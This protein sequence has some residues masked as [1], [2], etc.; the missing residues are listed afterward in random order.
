MALTIG[1]L[2]T[3]AAHVPTFTDLVRVADP[4][5]RTV[6]RVAPELL[7][8]AREHG[9]G[10]ALPARVASA[11]RGLAGECDVVVCTCSTIGALAVRAREVAVPVLRIDQPMADAAVAAGRRIGILAALDSTLAP[12]RA[13]LTEQAA[14]AG[15][16]IEVVERV[17]A[18][19]WELFEAGDLPGYHAAVAAAVPG[20][21][22]EVDVIVLAQ[23]S[24]APAAE[25]A[26]A[27]GIPVLA[28]PGLGV[29]AALAAAAPA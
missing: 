17:V 23:A 21:A 25:R 5:A 20:L 9:L 15:R 19:A 3:G 26:G 7:D 18:G 16:E 8:Q 28:S 6:H 14:A 24:M 22:A 4:G 11:V 1:F 10:G 2:H 12:T 29:A 13:L 27:I